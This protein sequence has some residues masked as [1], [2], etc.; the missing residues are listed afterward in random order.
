MRGLYY[1]VAAAAAVGAVAWI[2]VRKVPGATNGYVDSAQCTGCHAALAEGFFK[3]GMARS[4]ARVTAENAPAEASYYHAASDTHFAMERRG[5]EVWQRRWQIGFDG[6]E[7]NVEE[8]R[9]DYVMG[10]GNHSRTYLHLTARNTL[11]QLPLQWYAEGG[12]M[13]AMSPGY[14]RADHP[15]STRLAGYEC[16]F[17]HNAYP[18]IPPGAEGSYEQ[19]L[20]AGIDCQRCHGP[21]RRHVELAGT[22]G[23]APEKIRDAILN[24][25]RLPAEQSMEVCMQCHL[26]TTARKLP[27]SLLRAY[28]TP[29]SYVAGDPLDDFR[30]SFDTANGDEDRFE[31]V[32]SAYRLR[33]SR[34]FLESEGK[35]QCITCHNPH[36]IP[37][38]EAAK[39]Y[40]NDKCQDCHAAAERPDGS[41]D[42]VACHM[43]KRRTDDEVHVV[44]TDHRIARFL[45]DGDL[46]AA[47]TET[48][49]T[50]YRGEVKP[51]YP[52]LLSDSADD[53]LDLARAQVR[54]G[55]NLAA[56]L[57]QFEAMIRKHR[58]ENA[59][60]YADLAEGLLASG[61]AA[62]SIQY[63]EEA[64]R[65]EPKSTSRLTRLAG[66]LIDA[67]QF[68]KAEEVLR[69]A[70]PQDAIAWGLL[71]AALSQ[72][73]KKAEARTALEKGIALDPELPELHKNL[74]SLLDANG[75]EK[76]LR[77]T[78]RILPGM[79]DVQLSLARLLVARGE[80]R[81]GIYHF[82]QA[83][84]IT[85]GDAVARVDYGRA[86]AAMNRVPA[87]EKQLREAVRL[88]PAMARARLELATM[89]RKK[90]DVAGAV[91]HL[92]AAASGND[93]E[94]AAAATELLKK[95][96]R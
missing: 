9:A 73:D 30:L 93:P 47:K 3:T 78:L 31:N 38:G 45:P 83:V 84:R 74:A 42:C 95:L 36:D 20:P 12:G 17:C 90:G 51:Y 27:A 58:P 80:L 14:D 4:F 70:A 26:Q 41:A 65:R 53:D 71:G 82:E 44:M 22:P 8:K 39:T 57:Q 79:A 66:A 10:S 46:L 29:F 92:R 23:T 25:R 76:E 5:D 77:A 68:S 88:D 19:P 86:L 28:S 75:E 2:A 33:Q 32:S 55:S 60:Y 54:D 40:Y 87:A 96:G 52:H 24:P 63:F 62:R 85:P 43:P 13:W 67:R 56:G 35:L 64:A 91:E 1:A 37:R 7:T 6:K 11:Q 89:L 21:G 50:P 34:C 15:G 49:A 72:Q 61:D 69:R 48:A 94:I 18:K 81:E 59:V 16:M